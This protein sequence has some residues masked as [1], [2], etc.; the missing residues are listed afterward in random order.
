MPVVVD[1]Q[2]LSTDRL[3]L[4]TFG[5]VLAHLQRENRLVVHVLIDGEEPDLAAVHALRQT[6][7]EP[8]TIYVETT[9]PRRM[10]NE[11]LDEVLAQVDLADTLRGEAV[12]SLRADNH[13][14]ALE[15]LSGCF[16]CWQATQESVQK[17]AQ[18]L[19]IDMERIT[20][21]DEPLA[22]FLTRFRDQLQTIRQSLEDRDFVTLTDTLAY[23]VPEST[24]RW[25]QAVESIRGVAG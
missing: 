15:K 8:H 9:E 1:N 17:V 20:A 10:A 4:R 3:G 6:P 13:G 5:Q 25:R 11:V 23:E 19:R 7:T 12:E 16:T 2:P 22:T 14:K 24:G 18:L 21:G